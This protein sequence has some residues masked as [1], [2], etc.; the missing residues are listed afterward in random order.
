MK[1]KAL[2]AAAL[3][4]AFLA[5]MAPAPQALADGA[6]STRNILLGIGA[7]AGTLIIINHNKKVHQKYAED[8]QKEASLASQRDDAQAAY[9]AEVRAYDN[10][11]AVNDELRHEVA[12]KDQIIDQQ[13]VALSQMGV[14]VQSAPAPVAVAHHPTPPKAPAG[15]HSAQM[16]SYGW[17]VF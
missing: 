3:V 13:K 10:Q 8:A 16:I 5:S 15:N 6:A 7:A 2:V 9:K 14:Q 4:A 11:V 12:V 1:T 17:G